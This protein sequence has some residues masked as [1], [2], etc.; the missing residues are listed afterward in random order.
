MTRTLRYDR[1][2]D[3]RSVCLN[4][5]TAAGVFFNLLFHHRLEQLL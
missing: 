3:A 4:D 1:G 5:I 2:D